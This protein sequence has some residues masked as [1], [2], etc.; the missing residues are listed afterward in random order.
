[1]VRGRSSLWRSVD[2]RQRDRAPVPTRHGGPQGG[3]PAAS[4]PGGQ[5]LEQP[6][7]LG[8]RGDS[9]KGSGQREPQSEPLPTPEPHVQTR[10][11]L[12]PSPPTARFPSKFFQMRSGRRLASGHCAERGDGRLS[13]TPVTSS[14]RSQ[15]PPSVLTKALDSRLVCPGPATQREHSTYRE[16]TKK[17]TKLVKILICYR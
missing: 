6:R 3:P 12:G 16:V 2:A 15:R 7:V 13:L 11:P 1:M 9:G 17:R 14:S 4:G 10:S 8:G 5:R